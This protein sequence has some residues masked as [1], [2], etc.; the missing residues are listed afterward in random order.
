MLGAWDSGAGKMASTLQPLR[1]G[2]CLAETLSDRREPVAGSGLHQHKPA[3]MFHAN[4]LRMRACRAIIAT[5]SACTSVSSLIAA[6][7][8]T[9]A[10]PS[11]VH[12]SLWLPTDGT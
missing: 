8:G 3:L 7:A 6:G 4:I 5:A 11:D 10:A 2:N 12:P 9:A 1:I